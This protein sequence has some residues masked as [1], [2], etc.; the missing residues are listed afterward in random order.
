MINEHH[1]VQPPARRSPDRL[2]LLGKLSHHLTKSKVAAPSPH[3]KFGFPGT[4]VFGHEIK[5]AFLA[6]HQIRFA[7]VF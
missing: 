7:A 4:S 1:H 5:N 3:P 6:P 2:V